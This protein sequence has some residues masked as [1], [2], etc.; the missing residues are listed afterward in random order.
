MG[1]ERRRP[2]NYHVMVTNPTAISEIEKVKRDLILQELQ[3]SIQDTSMSEEDF[4][5]KMQEM[6]RYFKY[7]YQDNREI[8]GNEI[9]RHYSKEQNFRQI[10]NY[11]FLD[12]LK[13]GE[14]SYLC[15]I[16]H[17]EPVLEKLNPFEVQTYMSG[18]SNRI[19]DA[20]VIVIT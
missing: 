9:L 11:G 12:G 17:G 16:V 6:D 3:R 7:E 4:Q 20:D 8:W 19:E 18:Y 5:K 15:D 14:E 2:F 10:F 13:F 1:E